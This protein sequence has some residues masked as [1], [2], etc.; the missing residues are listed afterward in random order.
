M[1]KSLQ[2]CSRVLHLPLVGSAPYII[3]HSGGMENNMEIRFDNKNIDVYREFFYQNRQLQE[4]AESVV[5]DIDDDIGKIAAVQSYVLLKSKDI[6]SRGVLITGEA[7]AALMYIT[8]N[9][10]RVSSLK[11]SKGFSLEYEVEDICPEAVAQINL[12]VLSAEARIINPRKVSVAFKIGAE[13]SCYMLEG[14]SVETGFDKEACPGLHAKFESRELN[15]ISAVCEKTFSLSEQ[16]S[17]PAAKPKPTRI[18]SAK[19]D[20]IVNDTQLIGTKVIVKGSAEIDLC[21]LSDGLNY[22]VKTEFSTAFSQIVDIGEHDMDS[23]FVIPSLTSIYYDIADSISGDKLLDIELHA[24]LQL[25]CRHSREVVYIS[26]AYSNLMPANCARENISV[27]TV[28]E[29]RK[30]K[31]SADERIS[32]M[33]DCADV[34]SLF[35]AVGRM[36]V[37]QNK[38]KAA[39]NVDVI[40]KNNSGQLAA[41]RRIMELENDWPISDYRVCSLRLTDV[42]MRPDGQYLDGH[43]SIEINC[44]ING[45]QSMERIASVNL[46][47]DAVLAFEEFP[48]V[49]LV[50]CDR[51][52]VWELA[53]TYH[54]SVEKI[55]ASNDVESPLEGRM[56]LIP[57]SI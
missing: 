28:L 1:S 27:N 35:V 52:S 39:V 24:V 32:I 38:L 34:L 14:L 3:S 37:E 21:Y 25:V 53:K 41:V 44:V 19:A 50:R 5:P 57:K 56:L 30:I 11:L 12:S 20:F 42:Y 17:L 55:S 33:D 47:E 22:P 6:T 31:L 13:L 4:T 51:E 43:L 9:G 23:C 26:D 15:V 8:E 7:T 10:D 36:S 40:Y 2:L 54:S 48:A 49:T 46:D 18:V 45:V 16:F 29:S